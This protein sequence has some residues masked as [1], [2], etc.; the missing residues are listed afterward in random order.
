MRL[1]AWKKI[2]PKINERLNGFRILLLLILAVSC[3]RLAF[4]NPSSREDS[5]NDKVYVQ[6]EGDIGYPGVYAFPRKVKLTELI[7]RGSVSKPRKGF[8][9]IYDNGPFQS[10]EK[11]I[12]Q[13]QRDGWIFFRDEIS[14]F[15]KITL[16]IP[17]SLNRESEEGLTAVP[18]IGPKLA[19]IIVMERNKRGGFKDLNEINELYGVGNKVYKKIIPYIDL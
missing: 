3:L 13:R 15:Y 2:K 11:V 6:V 12:I 5:C 9:A 4:N 17:V 7:E 10:G 19:R 8:S 18:G 1:L 16:G 14:A